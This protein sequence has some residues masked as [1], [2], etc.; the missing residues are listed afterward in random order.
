MKKILDL[1]SFL[2]TRRQKEDTQDQ[3]FQEELKEVFENFLNAK[4]TTHHLEPMNSYQRR[5]AHQLAGEFE[6]ET[7]SEGEGEERHIVLKKK[8][9]KGHS[10]KTEKKEVEKSGSAVSHSGRANHR[11]REEKEEK[12][13]KEAESLTEKTSTRGR[14]S[15]S[16]FNSTK[17]ETETSVE[18]L[19]ANKATSG[20]QKDP[21]RKFF[22]NTPKENTSRENSSGYDFGEREFLVPIQE[23]GVEI[24]LDANGFVGIATEKNQPFVDKKKVTLGS[25][26][27]KKGKIITI[28]QAEW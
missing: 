22:E 5:L 6:I 20:Y 10:K 13:Q 1:K 19:S 21:P 17:K 18:G 14:F 4:E 24:I 28:D 9:S 16:R 23:E 25:F 12:E 7:E 8:S 26:K 27:V 3:E 15:K 2:K 11:G